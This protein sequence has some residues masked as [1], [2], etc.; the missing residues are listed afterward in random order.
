MSFSDS[1]R[2]MTPQFSSALTDFLNAADAAGHSI[3]MNS[4][5]RSPERQAQLWED[6][7][8]KYGSA[9]AARR[10]VAPPGRSNHNHGLA[11]DLGYGSDAAREWAHSNAGQYGLNFRMSWEPWHIELASAGMNAEAGQHDHA[12]VGA[13]S[14]ANDDHSSDSPNVNVSRALTDGSSSAPEGASEE[15]Q[16]FGNQRKIDPSIRAM[17]NDAQSKEIERAAQDFVQAMTPQQKMVEQGLYYKAQ[18]E[19]GEHRGFNEW[20]AANRFRNYAEEFMRGDAGFINN[21]SPTQHTMLTQV[22]SDVPQ[23]A[24]FANFMM[25]T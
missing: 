22:T 6:A 2:G 19:S 15:R 25:G 7:L 4:G 10:W 11:A 1:L 23:A 21:L 9:D 17:A 14:S 5:Y 3:T 20:F 12:D 13:S 24:S 8:E 18:L 16:A